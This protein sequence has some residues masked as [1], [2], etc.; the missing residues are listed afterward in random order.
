M[1]ALAKSADNLASWFSLQLDH[2]GHPY[3][4]IWMIRFKL[5]CLAPGFFLNPKRFHSPEWWCFKSPLGWFFAED[6]DFRERMVPE[7]MIQEILEL[8]LG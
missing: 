5:S 4:Q 7:E 2:V 6:I 1:D 3:F 8:W